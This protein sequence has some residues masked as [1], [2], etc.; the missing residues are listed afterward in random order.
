MD[1]SVVIPIKDERD[2]LPL[3]HEQLQ[4]VL[5]PTGWD[6][7]VIFVDDGSVDGSMEILERLAGKDGRLKVVQLTRNFGQTPALRAGIDHAQGEIIVT[8]DGDLQND[9]AD[10]PVL[11]SHIY[12]G[13]DVV[14]GWRKDR[15]DAL[16][17]RK[18][19]SWIANWLIRRVTHSS[20]RDLGCTLRAMR[21][22]VALE[23]PQYGEMHRFISVLLQN[24]GYRLLQVP[25]RHHP[26]R[27]GQTK[28]SLSRTVRVLLD[29]ITVRFLQA[30]LTRPM[31]VFGLGGVLCIICGL[32][33]LAVAIAQKLV[34]AERLNRN[35]LL[36]LSVLLVVVG[37]Q[38]ISLGLIGELLTRT[39]FESQGKAAYRVR[40]TINIEKLAPSRARAA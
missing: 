15:Q 31:H 28:Y 4:A 35:P 17:A 36:L 5:E 18:I 6:Y 1:V 30:Y 10:I 11:V 34:W 33:T 27:F 21:R 22:E 13:Y 38:F 37:V 16:L 23:L 3:L 39:Y 9:P 2:N 25:V 19:P 12:S 8:M 26:R 40:R 32:L 29:L 20:V 24:S 7:E 14:L